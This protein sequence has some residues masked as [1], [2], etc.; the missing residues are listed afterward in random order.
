MTERQ[1]LRI[2]RFYFNYL[3]VIAAFTSVFF[4]F[5][6]SEPV[7]WIRLVLLLGVPL[8]IL[9]RSK[10]RQLE[11]EKKE[12]KLPANHFA[13]AVLAGIIGA[14]S[15][16]LYEKHDSFWLS[17][18]LFAVAIVLCFLGEYI[19]GRYLLLYCNPSVSAETRRRSGRNMK[20]YLLQI[21]VAGAVVLL[22]LLVVVSH[23]P[24]IA[25]QDRPKTNTAQQEPD[26]A[27]APMTGS[28]RERPEKIQ[29]EQ[30]EQKENVFLQVLRY[31]LLVAIVVMGAVTVCYGL[32]RLLLYL[33]RGRRKPVWE[34]EEALT[35]K[36]EDEEYTRL[37]P[38]VRDK[39]R[40]PDGN[41]GKIRR[42]FYKAV[43]RQAGGQ[44]I[45]RSKTPVELKETYLGVDEKEAVLTELY[46]KAR[47]AGES[48]TEEEIRSWEKM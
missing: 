32:F 27:P 28:Q 5:D 45:V 34:F 14:P 16:F 19:R 47:Y 37:V 10:E 21:A 22:L 8:P 26:R 17:C 31:F 6:A 36:R 46:E 33:I 15:L 35:E 9:W 13:V 2:I 41:D 39:V 42:Q 7:S 43:K 40:F 44:E 25:R 30:E 4:W 23:E 11:E 3:L 12:K 29:E 1:K 38:V 20:R 24:E 48:V 18:L